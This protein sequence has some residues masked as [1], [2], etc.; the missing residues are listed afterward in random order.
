MVICKKVVSKGWCKESNDDA[1]FPCFACD[2][3]RL[4]KSVST[5]VNS[6]RC[7]VFLYDAKLL[8]K[9]HESETLVIYQMF[10][11]HETNAHPCVFL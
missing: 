3:Q 8:H 5:I 11:N 6:C 1:T 9:S 10:Q 2:C 4:S 7:F